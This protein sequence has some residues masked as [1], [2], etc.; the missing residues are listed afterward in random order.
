MTTRTTLYTKVG[1]QP[2]ERYVDGRDPAINRAFVKE[3]S[4]TPSE[5]TAD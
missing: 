5:E 3:L 1:Y 2:T 4:R